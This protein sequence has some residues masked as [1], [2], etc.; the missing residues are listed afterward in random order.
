M[1]VHDVC[2]KVAG[3]GEYVLGSEA[4]GSHACYLIYGVLKP[5][6]GGRVL[7]PGAGHEELILCLS[8]ELRLIGPEDRV[9]RPG[10]ALH[11]QGDEVCIAENRSAEDAVYV[12]AGG[13]AGVGH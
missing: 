7:K 6:E 4:T 10:Q 1:Q 2:G 12:A 3:S 11:L 13:H 9:L 8:G 5:G